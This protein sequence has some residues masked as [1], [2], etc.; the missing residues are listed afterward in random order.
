VLMPPPLLLLLML[1]LPL[2]L[3]L[4]FMLTL[5]VIAMLQVSFGN[6]FCQ[7]AAEHPQLRR[8]LL[9]RR[10]HLKTGCALLVKNLCVQSCREKG[11]FSN[12]KC[13]ISCDGHLF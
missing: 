7:L 10:Q 6:S 8:L 1:V 5:L 9:G 4:L 11:C 2:L 12:S 13:I 3:L